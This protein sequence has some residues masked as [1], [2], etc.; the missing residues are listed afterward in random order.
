MASIQATR[1][2]KGMLVKMGEDLFR[3]LDSSTSLPATCA[4]LC[5]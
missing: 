2:K 1:V 3:I 4:G 5:A